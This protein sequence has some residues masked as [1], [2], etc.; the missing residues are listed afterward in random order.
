MG[1]Y[2]LSAAW[3]FSLI[4]PAVL[5]YFLKLKRPRQQVP[6]LVLWRQV[7]ADSRVNSPFQKFKRNILLLLQLILLCLLIMGAMQPYIRAGDPDTDRLLVLLDRSA[8]MAA[9][10]KEGGISRLDKA[11]ERLREIV[12]TL[13]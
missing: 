7:L 1:F 10:D 4:A 11:K 9:F 13:P 3:L 12:E 2:A 8:S 6:S 5:L